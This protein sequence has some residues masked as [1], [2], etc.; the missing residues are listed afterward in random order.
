MTL[1]H[2]CPIARRRL[3]ISSRVPTTKPFTSIIN[4]LQNLRVSNDNPR[5]FSTTPFLSARKKQA[6]K[7]DRRIS[8]FHQ[9]HTSVLLHPY[10]FPHHHFMNIPLIIPST[11]SLPPS[12]PPNAPA[13]PLL[14]QPLP[15]T[16]DNP[17]RLPPLPLQTT[18]SP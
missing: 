13:P 7:K 11:N 18:T 6:Q 1:I 3:I 2:R 4:G 16:L 15:P 5:P 10:Q 14:S 9:T 12:T 17:P 8:M